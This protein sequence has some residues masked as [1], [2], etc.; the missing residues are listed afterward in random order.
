MR[1]LRGAVRRA[2][3]LRPA[4]CANAPRML[5]PRDR[6]LRR[7]PTENVLLLRGHGRRSAGALSPGSGKGCHRGGPGPDGWGACPSGPAGSAV[8]SYDPDGRR[9]YEGRI[10]AGLCG[11][12]GRNPIRT[13][14]RRKPKGRLALCAVC[15][16]RADDLSVGR[17]H[18]RSGKHCASCPRVLTGEARRF[19]YCRPCEPTAV[20]QA[21]RAM[22]EIRE[23]QSEDPIEAAIRAVAV[24]LGLPLPR[25]VRGPRG[26]YH[27]G[28]RAVE[29]RTR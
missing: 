20:T 23:R 28:P 27:T 6:R 5:D 21:R 29:R 9:L 4:P 22:R 17:R 13:T 26:P 24:A 18:G 25:K 2:R 7:T 8:V 1:A 11:A 16:G 14:S 15:V 12:C 10:A 19:K 3:R